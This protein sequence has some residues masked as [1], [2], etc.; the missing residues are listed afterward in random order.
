MKNALSPLTNEYRFLAVGILL[1]VLPIAPLLYFFPA[2]T[3]IFWGWIV[4]DPRAA[5]LIGAGYLSG[6][7][8]FIL[9]LRAN[10]W[11]QIRNGMGSLFL[12]CLFLL[13]ASIA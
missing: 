2:Q 11:V 8:Y 13:F 6:I 9:V 5:T 7:V 4:R 1:A 12:F 10:E 3:D